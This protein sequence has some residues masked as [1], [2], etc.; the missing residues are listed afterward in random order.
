MPRWIKSLENI[1]ESDHIKL[2]SFLAK[3]FFV[4]AA[5]ITFYNHYI[6][7]IY[8]KLASLTEKKKKS[9]VGF[10]TG[11]NFLQTY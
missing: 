8:N 7:S 4:F 10:A 9:F 11:Y 6:F 1:S 5:I 2:F 3:N